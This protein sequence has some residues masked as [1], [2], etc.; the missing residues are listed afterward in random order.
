MPCVHTYIATQQRE[1]LWQLCHH[2]YQSD[3]L[4]FALLVILQCRAQ[5]AHTELQSG[6]VVPPRHA[7]ARRA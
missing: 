4:E 2:A 5:Q 3:T 1:H 6:A 7:Q